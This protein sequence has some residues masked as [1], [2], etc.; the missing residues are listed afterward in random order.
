[1]AQAIEQISRG[2]ESQ[3]ELVSRGSKVIHEMAISV[4]LVARRAKEAAKAARDTSFTAQRGGEL[5]N[6]SL[7]RMK[8]FF[9]KPSPSIKD[10]IRIA[11]ATS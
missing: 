4:D 7:E 9:D 3:A 2:A 10:A 5:A 6:D 8:S 11:N 1:M